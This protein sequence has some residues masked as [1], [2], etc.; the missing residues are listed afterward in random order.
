VIKF[1]SAG[2]VLSIVSSCCQLIPSFTWVAEDIQYK[3][4][5]RLGEKSDSLSF[6]SAISWWR[7][8]TPF[9]NHCHKVMIELLHVEFPLPLPHQN[10]SHVFNDFTFHNYIVNILKSA[11]LICGSFPW[12][13]S[14][15]VPWNHGPS[16]DCPDYH[17]SYPYASLLLPSCRTTRMP[18]DELTKFFPH[19]VIEHVHIPTHLVLTRWQW[20]GVVWT[21]RK[22]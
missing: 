12:W 1:I 9:C 15:A 7:E 2:L 8:I 4:A 22:M 6:Q 11:L 5:Y 18:R 19:L 14:I 3:E 20:L 16:H 21:Y 13:C 10:G 17:T